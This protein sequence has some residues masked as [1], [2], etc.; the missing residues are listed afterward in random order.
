VLSD[1]PEYVMN[2]AS[3]GPG[4]LQNKMISAL[5]ARHNAALPLSIG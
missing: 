5:L 3:F 4:R 1:R 2:E